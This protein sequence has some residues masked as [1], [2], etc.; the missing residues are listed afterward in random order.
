ML[1]KNVPF[2]LTVPPQVAITENWISLKAILRGSLFSTLVNLLITIT[3]NI[4]YYLLI[5]DYLFHT[6]LIHSPS[7]CMC[8]QFFCN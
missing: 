2:S 4:Y 6:R 5:T 1:T 8:L 3:I 7:H